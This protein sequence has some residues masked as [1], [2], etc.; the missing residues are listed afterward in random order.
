[1][2]IKE[3]DMHG[4]KRA[5][6]RVE[7]CR[8]MEEAYYEGLQG[9]RFIHGFNHGKVLK[10]YM[11]KDAAHGGGLSKDLRKHY[12]E[13]PSVQIR[14]EGRGVTYALFDSTNP[15]EEIREARRKS[16]EFFAWFANQKS[17]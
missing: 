5:A 8:C 6:A 10:T 13:L 9:V 4:L 2:A 14:I 11:R 12:P 17:R 1:M 3:F 7:A 15:D 16:K